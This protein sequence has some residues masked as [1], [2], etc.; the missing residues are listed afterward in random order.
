[1]DAPDPGRFLPVSARSWILSALFN[2]K[3]FRLHIHRTVALFTPIA[4]LADHHFD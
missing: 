4:M 3:A 2:G 1:M